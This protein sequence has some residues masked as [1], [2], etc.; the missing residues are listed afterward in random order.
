MKNICTFVESTQWRRNLKLYFFNDKE[1][2]TSLA[3]LKSPLPV[4]DCVDRTDGVTP[5]TNN[6]L[7]S[8]EKQFVNNSANAEFTSSGEFHQQNFY[9]FINEFY[10][11]ADAGS[12]INANNQT[13][14]S[15][16]ELALNVDESTSK[17]IQH[18]VH[19]VNFQNAFIAGLKD[20]WELYQQ[21]NNKKI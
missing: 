8:T 1:S 16:L 9:N 4:L 18:M 10:D 5:R 14:N 3:A 17:Y 6:I 7:M 2:L 21:F 11:V 13:L 20:K 15:F 12:F 19:L